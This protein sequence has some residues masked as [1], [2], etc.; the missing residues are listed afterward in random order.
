MAAVCRHDPAL[1]YSDC[2]ICDVLHKDDPK[3]IKKPAKRTWAAAVLR[4]EVKE[5]GKVVGYRDQTRTVTRKNSD[6]TVGETFEE[7]AVVNLNFGWKNFFSALE[8]NANINGGTLLDR[9]YLIIRKGAD[10]DTVYIFMALDRVPHSDGTTFDV[11]KPEHMVKYFPSALT[12][13]SAAASDEYL[14]PIIEGKAA[15]DYF[16]TFFDRTVVASSNN[17]P[18]SSGTPSAAPV[19]DAA[20]EELE[21]L[22]A[23]VRGYPSPAAEATSE[24]EKPLVRAFD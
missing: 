18:V 15:D 20:N 3:S 10:V 1:S 9:D 19:N 7:P 21:A 24:D 23:R 12:I 4:E 2:Y 14:I 13:G 22:R 5:D 6:G 11:R 16:A 17:S 8:T